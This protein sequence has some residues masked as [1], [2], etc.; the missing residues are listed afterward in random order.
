MKQAVDT[1]EHFLMLQQLAMAG[2][3]KCPV[4]RLR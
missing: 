3:F 1:A 4:A 2:L